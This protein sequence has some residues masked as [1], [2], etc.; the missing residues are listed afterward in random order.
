MP[1]LKLA[2]IPDRTPVK[3]AISIS[4]DLNVDLADYA[5]LYE[6]AYGQ[7]ETV[8]DLIPY[9]LRAFLDSDRGFTKMRQAGPKS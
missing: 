4:P 6:N 8:S 2:R 3:L 1:D 5:T 9:M 7:K